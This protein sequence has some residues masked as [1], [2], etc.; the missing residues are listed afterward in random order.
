VNLAARL[1][2]VAA[3][4]EDDLL[5]FERKPISPS[6]TIENSSSSV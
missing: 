1:D 2:D 5:V 6:S 3:G 4:T